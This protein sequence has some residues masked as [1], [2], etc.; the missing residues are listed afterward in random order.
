M[1][2]KNIIFKIFTLLIITSTLLIGCGNSNKFPQILYSNGG[3]WLAYESD[4][5]FNIEDVNSPLKIIFNKDKTVSFQQDDTVIK[6]NYK[7]ENGVIKITD[8]IGEQIDS[9]YEKG[10]VILTIDNIIIKDNE[11]EAMMKS[12]TGY[13]HDLV[14]RKIAM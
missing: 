1:Y 4:G 8:P 2:K 10:D 9:S 7:I 6:G 12:R 5:N 11:L 13:K 14:F 3:S